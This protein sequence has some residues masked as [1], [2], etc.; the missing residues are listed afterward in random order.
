MLDKMKN[1]LSNMM[2]KVKQEAS[3]GSKGDQST[4]QNNP[5]DQKQDQGDKG[6]KANSDQ[7]QAAANGDQSQQAEGK[8]S[9]EAGNDKKA[10]KKTAGQD[11]KNGIGSQDGEKAIK[12]AEQ[13]QAMGKITE[14]LG[15]RSA[16]VSGEVMVEVG[17]SKQQLKTPWAQSQAS[18][19]NSGRRDSSRRDSADG[20]AVHRALLR[21]SAQAGGACR[22]IRRSDNKN[23]DG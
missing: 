21:G 1:A 10:S 11:S 7:S 5:S 4:P 2:D 17:S 16:A 18:H 15:K 23:G 8:Q 20:A 12:Q 9:S 13:L 6:Q 14:I 19:T 3:E 22:P